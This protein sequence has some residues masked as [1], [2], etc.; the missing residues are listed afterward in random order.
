[1][2]RTTRLAVRLSEETS[3]FVAEEARRSGWS[4]S[5]VVDELVSEAAKAR[6]FPGIAFRDRPRRAR[7][8]G[9]GLDVWQLID[10]IDAYRGDVKKLCKNY[11]LVTE[12]AVGVAV[13]YAE[14]FPAEIEEFLALQRRGEAQLRALYPFIEF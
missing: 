11:E 14:R 12:R 2:A 9:T 5:A 13:A 8:I 1:M 3:L 10:L 4:R 7:V 6:L